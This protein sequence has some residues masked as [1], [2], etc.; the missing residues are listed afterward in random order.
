MD[1]S[2][3]AADAFFTTDGKDIWKLRTYCMH[4][5]CRLENLE[6]PDQIESFG[7]GGLAAQRFH[8]IKMPETSSTVPIGAS[9]RP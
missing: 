3:L 6:N 5:T 8:R 9:E 7:M 4:P 2:D 1:S